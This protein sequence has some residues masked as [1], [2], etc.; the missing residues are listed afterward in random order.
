MA[1]P[2]RQTAATANSAQ[3]PASGAL[4]PASV[5]G[6]GVKGPSKGVAHVVS[7]VHANGSVHASPKTAYADTRSGQEMGATAAAVASGAPVH[8]HAHSNTNGHANGHGLGGAGAGAGEGGGSGAHVVVKMRGL[9]YSASESDIVSFFGGLR[10]CANGVSI[11]KDANGR[12]S[13]EAHVEFCSE[14]DASAAMSLNRQR[15]GS[16]YIELFRTK[17]L[18]MSSRRAERPSEGGASETLKL[19][20]M[21]FHSTEADVAAFFKGYAVASGGIKLGPQGGHGTVRFGSADE[22]RR[23]LLC[24]N[25]S[26]MGSRYI[27]LFST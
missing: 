26:Y 5:Q 6:S 8:S 19:R 20:G 22:A 12:A 15:I 4:T 18:P 10:I 9:P 23:A 25:H 21:P 27:E 11:G 13:G 1:T 3:T 16:R 2:P 17:Q 14:H 24:L 7:A